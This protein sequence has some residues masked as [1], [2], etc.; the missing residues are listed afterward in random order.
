[1]FDILSL[2]C[3]SSAVEDIKGLKITS[4]YGLVI[5]SI[6]VEISMPLLLAIDKCKEYPVKVPAVLAGGKDKSPE[7]EVTVVKTGNHDGYSLF[8]CEDASSAFTSCTSLSEIETYRKFACDEKI[9]DYFF[10]RDSI[11]TDVS[12]A[13]DIS[14]ESTV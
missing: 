10:S 13:T 8:T 9:E 11:H 12:H 2:A 6:L 1:V 3:Y 14:L 7:A 4:S 5:F